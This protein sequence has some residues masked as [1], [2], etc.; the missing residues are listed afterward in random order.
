MYPH[1]VKNCLIFIRLFFL[2]EVS[3]FAAFVIDGSGILTGIIYLL[4]ILWFGYLGYITT[5]PKAVQQVKRARMPGKCKRQLVNKIREDCRDFY[6]RLRYHRKKT[7]LAVLR[8]PYL[9]VPS[10]LHISCYIWLDY[11]IKRFQTLEDNNR[12]NIDFTN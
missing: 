6:N 11:E 7:I 1:P 4:L 2:G 8:D 9:K 5:E 3:L 12:W 10:K